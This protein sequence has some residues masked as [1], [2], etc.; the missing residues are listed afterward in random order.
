MLHAYQRVGV[1]TILKNNGKMILAD[2]P[3]LGKTIQVL[4]S[5]HEADW[6]PAVI[7]CPSTAKGV[8]KGEIR[9]WF[10][11]VSVGELSGRRPEFGEINQI[12]LISYDVLG[13]WANV[14][15]HWIKPR[16]LVFDEGHALVNSEI[17]RY[18]C[19][20]DLICA[21]KLVV[22]GTPVLNLGQDLI[23][24]QRLTG[25]KVVLRR[26]K[27]EVLG[28]L[29]VAERRIIHVPLT[30]RTEYV[31]ARDSFLTWLKDLGDLD[32][33]TAATRAEGFVRIGYLKRLISEGKLLAIKEFMASFGEE[34]LIIFA[35]HKRTIQSLSMYGKSVVIDGSK[36]ATQR[37]KAIA[38]FTKPNGANRLIANII[39]GGTAWN[40]TV[41]KTV[42]IAELPWTYAKLEQAEKRIDR[43][44]QTCVPTSH[45]ILG[46][47]TLEERF[48]EII[49]GKRDL[50]INLLG[51]KKK[52]WWQLW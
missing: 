29:Q 7:V 3:G 38:D 48:W 44:G 15:N 24:L 11:K 8:W 52:K 21:R 45:I 36:T 34:K 46:A 20:L 28:Q 14:I 31:F 4:T 13:E 19:A 17:G 10:P 32:K 27:S 22:T 49:I 39:S 40:G 6:L 33:V 23:N 37:S 51:D 47:D 43:I 42:I 25:S 2:E 41:S 50:S 35:I 12:N 30:N 1:D 9:K 16:I 5:L 18:K 26:L